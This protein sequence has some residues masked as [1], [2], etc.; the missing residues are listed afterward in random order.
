MTGRERVVAAMRRQQPDRVP[1]DFSFGFARASLRD[2][3]RRYGVTDPFAY[4]E[5]DARGVGLAPTRLHVDRTAY[6]AELPAGAVLDEWGIAH[7]LPDR[8]DPCHRHLSGITSPMAA[9]DS[10]R[11]VGD[12]P[13]PDID[14]VYRYEHL[15]AQVCAYHDCGLAVCA[16]MACT[17][18][19]V[20]A[21]L[22]GTA[23]LLIDLVDRP[24]IAEVLLGRIVDRRVVQA[25]RF[26]E[27][28][29]DVLVTGDDVATQRG[30][31]MSVALWR[32]WILPRLERVI[33]AARE[34]RSDILIFYH[35]DG[36]MSAIVPDLIGAG[37]DILNPVQPD[38]M[39]LAALKHRYG[40]RLAF[41]GG[42]GTHT[43]LT[44]GTPDDVRRE[45]RERLEAGAAGGGLLLAP[46]QMIGPEVPWENVEALVEAVRELGR[47]P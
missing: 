30:L 39:D 22:R 34:A 26:A 21:Y 28:G 11:A 36:D 47:Y 13:L 42:I 15:P 37:V 20:A 25:R 24:E 23:E 40:D 35:G 27:C 43:L 44:R 19:E 14:A 4:F 7:R 33:A 3:R 5:T 6:H 10:V 46:T 32:R 8:A 1:F 17:I 2:F 18:L 45:V 31:L 9:L 29:A 16:S 12:Y 38:C 41:W